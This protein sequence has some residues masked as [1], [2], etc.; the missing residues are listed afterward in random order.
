MSHDT[1]PNP[2]CAQQGVKETFPDMIEGK[3]RRKL[4][5]KAESHRSVWF[6]MGMFGVVG[7]AVA[8]PTLLGVVAGLWID[9]RWPSR[10]SWT[11]M[12]LFIGV[13]LGCLNAWYWIQQESDPE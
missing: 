7:W 4:K 2:E 13:V 8:I 3:V 11:L 9:Q 12:L 10:F 5:A 6:G 1:E